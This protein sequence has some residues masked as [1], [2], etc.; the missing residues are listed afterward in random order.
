M[1]HMPANI[2]ATAHDPKA[3]TTSNLESCLRFYSDEVHPD[4]LELV[5]E[6]FARRGGDPDYLGVMEPVDYLA[7]F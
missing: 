1:A 4:D 5:A 6:E 2:S 7:S 3:A